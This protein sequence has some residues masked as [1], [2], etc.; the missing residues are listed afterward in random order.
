MSHC[1]ISCL[2]QFLTGSFIISQ[3]ST[4]G[5]WSSCMISVM[6]ECSCIVLVGGKIIV[7]NILEQV[8]HEVIVPFGSA[9]NYSLASPLSEKGNNGYFISLGLTSLMRSEEVSLAHLVR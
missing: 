2:G 8:F 9:S 6:L 7:M 4:S 5:S 3:E 1:S